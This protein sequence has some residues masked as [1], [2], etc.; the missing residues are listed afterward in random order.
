MLPPPSNPRTHHQRCFNF[1]S[2]L[3]IYIYIKN[4]LNRIEMSVFFV[5]ALF[6]ILEVQC[7][8]SPLVLT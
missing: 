5:L 4:E 1:Y 3:G 7:L 8:V 2:R 6:E